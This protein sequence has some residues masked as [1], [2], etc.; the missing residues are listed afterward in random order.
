[1]AF[2]YG[3]KKLKE[4][5]AKDDISAEF[6]LFFPCTF[7]SLKRYHSGGRPDTASP[8]R[9][10]QKA[11]TGGG[12]VPIKEKVSCGQRQENGEVARYPGGAETYIAEPAR[13]QFQYGVWPAQMYTPRPQS[14]MDPSDWVSYMTGTLNDPTMWIRA[15]TTMSDTS[16]SKGSGST[17]NAVYSSSDKKQENNTG[18]DA[19]T[20]WSAPGNVNVVGAE[21]QWR[22]ADVKGGYTNQEGEKVRLPNRGASYEPS[23]GGPEKTTA[24]NRRYVAYLDPTC[25]N[26]FYMSFLNQIDHWYSLHSKITSCR[27]SDGHEHAV[28]KDSMGGEY[29]ATEPSQESARPLSIDDPAGKGVS[30]SRIAAASN[31]NYTNHYVGGP[32]GFSGEVT[33]KLNQ[34]NLNSRISSGDSR[35]LSTSG[36]KSDSTLVV[37]EETTSH[38]KWIGSQ[39]EPIPSID[40]SYQGISQDQGSQSMPHLPHSSTQLPPFMH[41]PSYGHQGQ[42]HLGVSKP[43]SSSM[44]IQTLN[45]AGP[46]PPPLSL[47]STHPSASMGESTLGLGARTTPFLNIRRGPVPPPLPPPY[48]I[49]MA[50]LGDT[51]GSRMSPFPTSHGEEQRDPLW[52]SS[53]LEVSFNLCLGH[54]STRIRLVQIL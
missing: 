50:H 17:I 41:L 27:S 40:S 2:G 5:L 3:A 24:G 7:T 13:P 38:S 15:P 34:G 20:T 54:T 28:P 53:S 26:L 19:G 33:T 25:T 16:Y 37:E 52:W 4:V 1:M 12:S 45:L 47:H 10:S 23:Q 51:T 46:P 14:G 44:S 39:S 42:I 9:G 43:G 30:Q 6:K 29:Q 48:M 18:T 32:P 22:P 8:S 11:S 21:V 36:R 31:I 49:P 35:D